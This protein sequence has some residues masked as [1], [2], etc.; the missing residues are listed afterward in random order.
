MGIRLGGRSMFV[1]LNVYRLEP[2]KRKRGGFKSWTFKIRVVR[3]SSFSIVYTNVDLE[4][5][6]SFSD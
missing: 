6:S 4:K 5:M 1:T 2:G 3:F